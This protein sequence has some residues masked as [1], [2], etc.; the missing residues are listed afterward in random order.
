MKVLVVSSRY[1]WPPYT[2]DRVRADIWLR[3]LAS[4]HDVTFI[5]P[6]SGEAFPLDS[7]THLEA[8]FSP[9]AIIPASFKVLREGLP[10]HALIAATYDWRGALQTAHARGGRFDAAVVLLSRCE[11]WVGSMIQAERKIL[12]AI[13]SLAASTEERARAAGGIGRAFWRA[14]SGRTAALEQALASRYDDVIVVNDAECRYFGSNCRAIGNGVEIAPLGNT[15]RDFDIGFWGRLAYFANARAAEVLLTDVWPLIRAARPDA[16]LL[17]AGA[18]APAAIRAADGRDGVTVLSPMSDRAA[19]LRR[20]RVALFPFAFGTGQSN[21]VLEAA[22]AGCA[23]VSTAQGVRGLDAI[24]ATSAVAE[25]PGALA[26][27]ALALLNDSRAR[28]AA[29]TA[30]RSAVEEHYSR[31]ATERAMRSLIAEERTAR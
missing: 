3:A 4:D 25:E 18:D 22:E 27:A 17:I 12:D 31:A 19:T 13:D 11:P 10:A 8:R 29:A 2:G 21:K 16:R 23:I 14:E 20:V 28:D 24:A 26:A 6:P 5:S 1:P 30:A 7:V 15:P 9:P